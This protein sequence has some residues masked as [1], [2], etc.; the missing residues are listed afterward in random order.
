VTP[1]TRDGLPLFRQPVRSC[2]RHL[3][4]FHRL[5]RGVGSRHAVH[6]PPT[7]SK[8]GRP[9]PHISRHGGRG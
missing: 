4:V 1:R 3:L 6:G 9:H 5:T 7:T 8:P 2:F